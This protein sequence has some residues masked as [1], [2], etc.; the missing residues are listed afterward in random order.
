M[1]ILVDTCIWIDVERGNIS[2][3]D[4]ETYTKKEPIFISPVTI[5]ELTFG[6]ERAKNEDIK[7][8]RLAAV[9][10]LRKKPL[11]IIDEITGAIYGRIA[12]SICAHGRQSNYR[13]QDLWL[14]SQAVQHDFLFLTQNVKDFADIP[15]LKLMPFGA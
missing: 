8:K 10:R 2:P 14:A 11:L 4:V 12:A 9:N 5:A 6:V 7:H 1:G 13:T 3:A 15:G